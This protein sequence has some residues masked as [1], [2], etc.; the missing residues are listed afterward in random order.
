MSDCE[1][2]VVPHAPLLRTERFDLWQP[3]ASDLESLQ[4]LIEHPD[5]RRFLGSASPDARSQA[6]R[7]QRNAGSW[8]LY[9][10]GMFAV[11]PRGQGELIANCGVFHSWRGFGKG[12]DDTPEA[13]W[14]VRQDWWGKGVA[15][16]VMTAVLEWFDTVHGPRR[17]TCMIEEGNAASERLAAALG[18]VPYGN[19]VSEEGGRT[20]LKLFERGDRGRDVNASAG[21]SRP[22]G[23]L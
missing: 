10:S 1:F 7:L 9:G 13:G 18:F 2:P 15:G 8:A 4:R 19:H 16:E 23:Q 12:M 17:I 14:I 21:V 5:M 22:S 6:E 11:R 20:V 3:Q